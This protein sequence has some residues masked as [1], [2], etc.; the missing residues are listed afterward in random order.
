MLVGTD[1]SID[2]R[3]GEVLVQVLPGQGQVVAVELHGFSVVVQVEVS[4]AQLTV[5]GTQ[6]LQVLCANLDGRLKEGDT[7]PEITGFTEPLTLQRQLQAGRLH[8]T[9]EK[10]PVSLK[11]QNRDEIE[12]ESRRE[13]PETLLWVQLSG[14]WQ[15]RLFLR[16]SFQQ[17]MLFIFL[18]ASENNG[19][20]ASLFVMDEV[21]SFAHT[22]MFSRVFTSQTEKVSNLPV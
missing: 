10:S 11:V 7:R 15:Q 18:S 9:A 22:S 19:S 16:K 20:L 2:E 14:L 17:R 8:P 5:D 6:H 3:A 13:A 21:T 1:R 4:I 12:L